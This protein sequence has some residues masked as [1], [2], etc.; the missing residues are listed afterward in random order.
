MSGKDNGRRAAGILSQGHTRDSLR[1]GGLALLVLA[2]GMAAACGD[3]HALSPVAAS[4]ADETLEKGT[5]EPCSRKFILNPETMEGEPGFWLESVTT[6]DPGAVGC[7]S[8]PTWS[9]E[10][11]LERVWRVYHR[12][13][14]VAQNRPNP[15]RKGNW[16]VILEPGQYTVRTE[17]GNGSITEML[18]T[19]PD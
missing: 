17:N 3:V 19:V 6:G 16:A 10:K 11:A 9:V 2:A 5:P 13:S 15:D 7:Y 14:D 4:R 8:V 1:R 18:V 12:P